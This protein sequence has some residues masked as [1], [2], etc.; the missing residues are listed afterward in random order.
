VY[1]RRIFVASLFTR[2]TVEGKRQWIEVIPKHDYP[3]GTTFILRWLPT[4]GINYKTKYL[5]KPVVTF[6]TKK[7]SSVPE[8]NALRI[9]DS[10]SSSFRTRDELASAEK[11]LDTQRT[12]PR[13]PEQFVPLIAGVKK[14]SLAS[15]TRL[16][17]ALFWIAAGSVK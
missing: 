15:S 7:A 14:Q 1:P 5:G 8:R 13:T 16:P 11:K 6:K 4:G 2:P 12:K 10:F 3:Q 17:R 9:A